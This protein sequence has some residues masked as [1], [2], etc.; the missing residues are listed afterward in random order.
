MSFSQPVPRGWLARES[1]PAGRPLADAGLRQSLDPH[2][3]HPRRPLP[4]PGKPTRAVYPRAGRLLAIF[5]VAAFLICDLVEPAADGA[6]P[7]TSAWMD[8]IGAV[9]GLTILSGLYTLARARPAGAALGAASG[10]AMLAFTVMCPSSNHHQLGSFIVVQAALSGLVIL[11]SLG[12]RSAERR[13]RP[14]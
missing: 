8:A 10:V 11:A 4:K 3:H 6:E 12:L 13:A 5:I 9:G 14:G 7:T 1:G 2:P